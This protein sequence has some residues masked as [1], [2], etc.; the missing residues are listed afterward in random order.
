M[1]DLFGK[2]PEETP[3][4]PFAALA[5]TVKKTAPQPT[6]QTEHA[7]VKAADTVIEEL[8]Q[9]PTSISAAEFNSPEQSDT[10]NPE[11][12]IELKQCMEILVSSFGQKELVS[13]AIRAVLIHV[14]KYPFLKDI[15]LPEDCQLMVRALRESYGV[16]IVS[17][18]TR[19]KKTSANQQDVTEAEDLL[20]DLGL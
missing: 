7:L 14:K 18:T 8:Q 12:I 16:A 5:E 20:A 2:K 11:A 6:T 15:L 9:A 1:V 17:K 3:A 10:I 19:A 13:N 4:N